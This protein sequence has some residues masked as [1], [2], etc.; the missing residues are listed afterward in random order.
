MNRMRTLHIYIVL[1]TASILK[2]V[3]VHQVRK[4]HFLFWT[5]KELRNLLC[6]C[7]ERFNSMSYG[8]SSKFNVQLFSTKRL[9]R[10]WVFHTKEYD[11]DAY[12]IHAQMIFNVWVFKNKC[13]RSCS[14]RVSICRN[15][16][17]K[18]HFFSSFYFLSDRGLDSHFYNTIK[19]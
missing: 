9:Y 17:V 2:I 16:R 3:F 13:V 6:M 4:T 14:L 10:P 11:K 19:Q 1:S 8:N 12:S 15:L 5:H 18:W 7:N